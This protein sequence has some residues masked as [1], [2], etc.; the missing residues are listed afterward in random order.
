[1]VICYKCGREVP[2][3][4][5]TLVIPMVRICEDCREIEMEEGN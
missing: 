4:Y 3:E 1:M 5:T 2:R